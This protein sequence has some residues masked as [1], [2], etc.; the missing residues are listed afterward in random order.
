MEEVQ[1]SVTEKHFC[2]TLFVH[3]NWTQQN[4][5]SSSALKINSYVLLHFHSA[6]SSRTSQ[7][8][9]GCDGSDFPEPC[10]TGSG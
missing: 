7:L 2:V 10:G 3:R 1:N 8:R 5:D 9:G 6:H 4:S